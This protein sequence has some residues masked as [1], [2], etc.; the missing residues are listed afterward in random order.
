MDIRFSAAQRR[1]PPVAG[2]LAAALSMSIAPGWAADEPPAPASSHPALESFEATMPGWFP[3]LLGAQ[4]TVVNQKQLPFNSPYSGQNSLNGNGEDK[5][6]QTRAVNFGAQATENLQFYVDVEWFVGNG[7][8]GGNG[9]GGYSDGEVV[10]A[11]NASLPKNPYIARAFGQY[12]VPL[13]GERVSAERG[14]DQLP[15][16]MPGEYV[17]A[18]AGKIAASDDLDV[19]RYANSA[20]TQFLNFSFISNG[21][22]DFAADTRGYTYGVVLGIVRTSWALKWGSYLMPETANGQRLDTQVHES[23]GDNI[24]LTLKQLPGDA[25]LRLLAYENHARMGR[26]SNAI[27]QA[28]A[29]GTTPDVN[30]D[31]QARRIKYGFGIN[32]ELPLAD[33]GETGL[34]FRAGWND[35]RTQTFAYT[36]IDRDVGGGAQ[37]SGAHWGRDDDRVG[38]GVTA[39]FLS[40]PHRDY[41]AAGGVGF[42]VGDGR[43]N[44]APEE[45]AETYYSVRLV[46]NVRLGPDYQYVRNPGYNADRGPVHIL[47]FRIRASL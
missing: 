12:L 25:V 1:L 13:S 24:E 4:I 21:A 29:T 22:W 33:D 40:R 41:L 11:G 3:K 45:I 42:M 6:S 23:R 36:E 39:N 18:K 26:Y 44:Y 9:L 46:D 47:G 17:I 14:V 30:A 28:R 27:A 5:T 8:H 37:I 15:G 31:A 34:F 7:L 35:G 10:R 20:R 38:I 16:Q 2:A 32:G 19:N 43:I